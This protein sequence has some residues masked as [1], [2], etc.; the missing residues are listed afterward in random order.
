M[1]ALPGIKC[2]ATSSRVPASCD[3]AVVN[4]GAMASRST[5][6]SCRQV[7]SCTDTVTKKAGSL[8]F[9][10]DKDSSYHTSS[11]GGAGGPHQARK[12]RL[13]RGHAWVGAALAAAV[14]P[15]PSGLGAGS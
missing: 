7:G 1:P 11:G 14:L 4:L 9:L 2:T 8:S 15:L 13:A 12:A 5:F 6:P 10:K 3:Q